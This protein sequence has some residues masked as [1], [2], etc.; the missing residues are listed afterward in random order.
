MGRLPIGS[1]PIV[2]D[3]HASHSL[4]RQDRS[5]KSEQQHDSGQARGQDRP[6]DRHGTV[7]PVAATTKGTMV[8]GKSPVNFDKSKKLKIIDTSDAI[9]CQR[10]PSCRRNSRQ[11][12]TFPPIFTGLRAGGRAPESRIEP[13]GPALNSIKRLGFAWTAAGG[14]LHLP[15]SAVL[16][17]PTCTSTL[18]RALLYGQGPP[19][20]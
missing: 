1:A 17:S 8:A 13:R 18:V 4:G 12:N 5:G 2:H 15:D 6:E 3:L 20:E 19:S 9:I 16:R 7:D 11:P 14:G 10:R